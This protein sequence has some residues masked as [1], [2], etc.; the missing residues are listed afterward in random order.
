MICM[1]QIKRTARNNDF[2]IFVFLSDC[3][4]ISKSNHHIVYNIADLLLFRPEPTKKQGTD[5]IYYRFSLVK[6]EKPAKPK[7]RS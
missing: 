1:Q 7:I 2:L 4:E 3:F 5:F 6:F